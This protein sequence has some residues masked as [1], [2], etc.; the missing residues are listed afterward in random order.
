MARNKAAV[1]CGSILGP[2]LFNLS[3]NDFFYDIHESPVCSF[4]DDIYGCGQNLDSASNIEN[5]LKGAI[6][7]Y[8]INEIAAN[9]ENFQLLFTGLK[10]DIKIFIDKNRVAVQMTNKLNLLNVRI[11]LKRNFNQH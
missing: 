6:N 5:D 3:I 10:D 2:L 4:E 9:P 7:W 1:P 11:G 8:R